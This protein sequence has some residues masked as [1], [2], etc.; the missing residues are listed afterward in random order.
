MKKDDGMYNQIDMFHYR[1]LYKIFMAE[2]VS[3]SAEYLHTK[4]TFCYILACW[5]TNEYLNDL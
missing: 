4:M 5:V 2:R 1:L 3:I